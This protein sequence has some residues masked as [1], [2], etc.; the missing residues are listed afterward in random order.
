[1]GKSRGGRPE[2]QDVLRRGWSVFRSGG[3]LLA[4]G[5]SAV[6]GG[7]VAVVLSSGSACV[8]GF[9]FIRSCLISAFQSVK[10]GFLSFDLSAFGRF[11]CGLFV[12]AA[13]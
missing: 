6:F 2:I 3:G 12:L 8:A 9:F 1:M 11:V 10:T 7:V 5:K 13:S 4:R